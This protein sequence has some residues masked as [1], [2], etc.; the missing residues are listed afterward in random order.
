MSHYLYPQGDR[1]T[2][3]HVSVPLSFCIPS[4]SKNQEATMEWIR[5]LLR[6][7]N[8][9]RYVTIQ[10]C[11]ALPRAPG[12]LEDH[13][14]WNS[15]TRR[16][17]STADACRGTPRSYGWPGP[18]G[19]AASEVQSKYI[20]VDMLAR[21]VQGESADVAAAWAEK[22]LKNVYERVTLR[23]NA[24]SLP[25]PMTCIPAPPGPAG[26]AGVPPGFGNRNGFDEGRQSAPALRGIDPRRLRRGSRHA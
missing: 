12:A 20:V 1:G 3:L 11:F 23:R 13:P 18:F 24:K 21:A 17:P 5:Y 2:V 14:M 10:N 16:C 7:D 19:R 6:P 22:E 26:G 4:Y 9:E 8:Y 15:Q 25:F